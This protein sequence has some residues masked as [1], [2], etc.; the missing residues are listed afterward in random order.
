MIVRRESTIMRFLIR[1][2]TIV[3]YDWSSL[4]SNFKHSSSECP[5]G[6][7]IAESRFSQEF[8]CYVSVDILQC[9]IFVMKEKKKH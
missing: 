5:G 3:E 6:Y 1:A 9:T 2:L 8:G 4:V 7:L